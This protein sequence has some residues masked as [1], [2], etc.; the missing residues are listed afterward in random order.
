MTAVAKVTRW[1]VRRATKRIVQWRALARVGSEFTALYRV[2]CP[3]AP[4]L[5]AT[6]GRSTRPGA[7]N[8]A[9]AEKAD[10]E[11]AIRGNPNAAKRPTAAS[12]RT[13]VRSTA[14]KRPTP[15]SRRTIVQF[16]AAKRPTSASH[17][18]PVHLTACRPRQIAQWR[19][20]ARVG[21]ESTALYRVDCPLAPELAAAGGQ[22][23]RPGMV[24]PA[25]AEK[26]DGEW[27]IRRSPDA[28]KRPTAASRRAPVRSTAAKR[29]TPASRRTIVQLTAAK[30][31]TAAPPS[32]RCARWPRRPRRAPVRSMPRHTAARP[33]ARPPRHTAAPRPAA[34]GRQRPGAR[35]TRDGNC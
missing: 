10:G 24:N 26:A 27:A 21:S 1:S 2:D 32:R 28:A 8:P 16:T 18:A 15:A 14:A 29:P 9:L 20:L 25:L 33:C 30:R 13:P 23:T 22:S 7:A 19:A 11:W 5:A 4:E 31:P 35:P 6:F 12:R 34:T 3:L 17:R